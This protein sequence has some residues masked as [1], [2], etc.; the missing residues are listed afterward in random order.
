M[1]TTIIL[2]STI[3]KENWFFHCHDFDMCAL[4]DNYAFKNAAST[5]QGRETESPDVMV[6]Y[7]LI[8]RIIRTNSCEHRKQ[9]KPILKFQT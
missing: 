6:S 5:D 4:M 8:D 3:R 7:W 9:M 1:I 2:S